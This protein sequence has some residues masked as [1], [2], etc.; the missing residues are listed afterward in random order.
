MH[1]CRGDPHRSSCAKRHMMGCVR[2]KLL[3]VLGIDSIETNSRESAGHISVILDKLV[4]SVGRQASVHVSGD[5]S[6]SI[7]IWE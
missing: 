2:V 7:A 6:C 5:V 4:W 1:Y 3:A